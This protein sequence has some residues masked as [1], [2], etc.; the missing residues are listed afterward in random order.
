[1]TTQQT[2]QRHLQPVPDCPLHKDFRRPITEILP[3]LSKPVPKRFIEQRK[4][5]GATLDYI[6][7]YNDGQVKQIVT[8]GDR[9]FLTYAM[10]IEAA[11]GSFTREATGTELLKEVNRKSG[12][13]HELAYGDP[14]SNG[15][16]M[17]FR[18]ASAKFGLGLHLYEN[19]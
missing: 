1:M 17:A 6:P 2:D 13:I 12:E 15:E 3:D 4:Q 11:E 18:R 7:W 16:S 14:S 9:L 5:G 8:T 19:K 10:T